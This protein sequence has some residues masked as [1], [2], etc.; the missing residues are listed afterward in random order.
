[1]ILYFSGTGNSQFVA[2][3]IAKVTGDEIISMNQLLKENNFSMLSSAEYPFVFVVP[4]YAWRIPHV[5]ETFI[6]K[7]S[8]TGT[9]EVYF[10]L[11]CGGETSNAIHYVENL[12]AKKKFTLKGFAEVLMP[13]NYIIMFPSLEMTKAEEIVQNS[14]PTVKTIASD[15]AQG[16]SFRPCSKPEFLG[17]LESKMV[18]PLFYSLLVKPK[19][20]YAT[21]ACIS[22]KKCAQVC[23]LNNISF[24]SARPTWG[25]TCTH[26]MACICS[27]PT[28]AIEFK[29][30]T[31]DKTRYTFQKE[32]G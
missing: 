29:N 21:D 7:T 24:S 16:K 4:T 6:Q 2:H 27:C 25:K 8:F 31:K 19:G 10:V 1:M 9:S 23:P 5:V 32:W 20:F 18:N 3:Q 15:I 11:T 12:C 13:D 17:K 14:F 30:K 22:C 28:Q 26:C